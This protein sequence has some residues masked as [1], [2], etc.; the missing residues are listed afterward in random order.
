MV[1]FRVSFS[2]LT[3]GAYR[4]RPDVSERGMMA[5]SNLS[6]K[7]CRKTQQGFHARKSVA[8]K[9][10]KVSMPVKVLPRSAARFSHQG[11]C[12][13]A[14]RQAFP[15]W[16]NVP[17]ERGKVSSLGKTFLRSAARFPCCFGPSLLLLREEDEPV[18]R[19]TLF[20]YG[21]IQIGWFDYFFSASLRQYFPPNRQ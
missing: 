7:P 10:S 4:I 8:A 2:P 12:S 20:C 11:K 17:A 19:L 5:A 1:S 16:E 18:L 21:L 9:R 3:V 14:A 13:C 15:A 6:L